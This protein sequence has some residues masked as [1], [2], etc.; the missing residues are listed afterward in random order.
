VRP[1][2]VIADVFPAA[3]AQENPSPRIDPWLP[4]PESPDF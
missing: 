3:A 2:A 4:S 1:F